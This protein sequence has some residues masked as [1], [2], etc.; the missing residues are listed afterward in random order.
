MA[1]SILGGECRGF[2]VA[3]LPGD[4]VRPMSVRLK[5]RLFD[6]HQD[7][8][9]LHFVDLCGGSGAVGLE[10]WSRGAESVLFYEKNPRAYRNLLDNLA[11]FKQ[12]Y[13][14]A[15]RPLDARRGDC[16]QWWKREE[17]CSTG[18]TLLFFAP[19]YGQHQLY[20]RFL[21]ILAYAVREGRF[22]GVL[23]V[24]SDRQKGIS[25]QQ[26]ESYFA[27]QKTYQQ[28]TSFVSVGDFSFGGRS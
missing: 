15:T 26:V 25:L 28:G 9:G 23:W 7:L 14:C 6:A 4:S 8:S 20:H 21:Q 10:A 3:V 16:L 27:L 24:E 1:L 12:R 11:R 22:G 19:P 5:R 17:D 13:D 18:Q 2:R